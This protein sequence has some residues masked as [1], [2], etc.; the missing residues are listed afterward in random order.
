MPRKQVMIVG[1]LIQ[2][3]KAPN[4]PNVVETKCKIAKGEIYN[5]V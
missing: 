3:N 4:Y 1:K 5:R 2:L